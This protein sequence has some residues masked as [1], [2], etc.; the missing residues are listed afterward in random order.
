MTTGEDSAEPA[1]ERPTPTPEATA[2]NV[3]GPDPSQVEA[4]AE[5]SRSAQE[6]EA[7][8]SR[9]AQEAEAE[10]S[11]SA[12]QEASQALLTS[13]WEAQDPEYQAMLCHYL[14]SD[15]DEFEESVTGGLS[16]ES[17]L[18]DTEVTA[19]FEDTCLDLEVEWAKTSTDASTYTEL[20]TRDLALVMKD[21][22]AHSGERYVVYGYIWQFDAATGTEGFMA[23]IDPVQHSRSY[24][25]DHNIA[26]HAGEA[27]LFDDL[28]EGDIVRMHVQVRGAYSYDTQIGGNTTVPMLRVN[29]VEAVGFDD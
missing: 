10:A 26:A 9:S 28:V 22:D 24:D 7:E 27:G 4:E 17:G 23:R 8:A 3:E 12:E 2:E 6:A 29:I 1:S 5:A 21:P 13:V 15:P 18:T 19:F 16:S 11:R 25:F 20:S 14:V